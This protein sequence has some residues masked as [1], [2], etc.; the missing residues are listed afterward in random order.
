MFLPL[1]PSGV[2]KS[3][4][5]LEYQG[6]VGKLTVRSTGWLEQMTAQSDTGDISIWLAQVGETQATVSSSAGKLTVYVPGTRSLQMDNP[7]TVA[8]SI[9]VFAQATFI[10]LQQIKERSRPFPDKSVRRQTRA[11]I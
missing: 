9:S 5:R 3:A 7:Q 8:G 11:L 1:E 4:N 6:S 10:E 2:N